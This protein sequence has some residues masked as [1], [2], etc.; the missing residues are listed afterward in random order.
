MS[1][2]KGAKAPKSNTKRQS[3]LKNRRRSA[4]LV[5]LERWV[6]PENKLKIIE[7]AEM[8]ENE[9]YHDK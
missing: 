2:E 3:E 5:R 7:Y 8:L 1:S 6:T 9:D 4:G